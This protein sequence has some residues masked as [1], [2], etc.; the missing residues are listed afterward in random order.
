M[1][2]ITLKSFLR[3][4]SIVLILLFSQKSLAQKLSFGPQ[5]GAN[6][7]RIDGSGF[8]SGFNFGY[9]IGAF[10]KLPVG[11]K[12]AGQIEVLWSQLQS[13]KAGGFRDLYT[14]SA[15]D[16]QDPRLD[17]LAIPVTVLYKPKKILSIQGGLQYSILINSNKTPLENGRRAFKEGDVSALLGIHAEVFKFRAYARYLMGLSNIGSSDLKNEWKTSV[18][19]I[20]A[21]FAIF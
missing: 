6:I 9:H 7:A 15:A 2:L 16:F 5:L 13:Q 11:K 19:Q 20:G 18:I 17:Y 14:I 21:G 1:M 8:K 3:L 12:F 10:A 4:Q